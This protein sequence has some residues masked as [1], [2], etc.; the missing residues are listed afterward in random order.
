MYTQDDAY[1][2]QQLLK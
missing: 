1:K 2:G